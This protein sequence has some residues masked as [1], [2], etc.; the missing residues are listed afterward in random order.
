MRLWVLGMMLAV[1]QP[2]AALELAVS[3]CQKLN[4]GITDIEFINDQQAFI[5]EKGGRLYFFSGCDKAATELTRF[6]VD[7]R[8]ELG[9]LGVAV[10]ANKKYIYLYYSPKSKAGKVYTRLSAFA[11]NLTG[12]QP[13][14]S[15][16]KVLLEIEQPYNNHDGGSL[17]FGPDGNLYLGVGDGGSAADPLNAGQTEAMLLGSILRITPAP[18]TDKGYTLP[19]GNLRD[20]KAKAAPEIL[21]QGLRNPWKMAFDSGGNLI[22]ADVGQN[23]YEEVSIIPRDM[24]GRRALNLGWRLRE[25]G[26]CFKPEKNCVQPGLLEPVFEYDRSYGASITGGES[27]LFNDR[28]YYLFADFVS[29]NIGAL[30]LENPGKLASSQAEPSNR[31]TTFGKTFAGEVYIADIEGNVYRIGVK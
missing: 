4:G 10:P 6:S 8:S 29:G 11:L 21:A 1:V 24:I 23:L 13:A 14:L 31:W 9:L 15:N 16:E 20:F 17:K 28:E 2:V 25:A 26:H 5:T 7:A 18:G 3:H 12:A 22:V 27:V 30:D 19:K